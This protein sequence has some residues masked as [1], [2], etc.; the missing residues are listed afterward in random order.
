MM[1]SRFGAVREREP[2]GRFMSPSIGKTLSGDHEPEADCGVGRSLQ[3]AGPETRDP[4]PETQDPRPETRGQLVSV[5]RFGKCGDSQTRCP[6]VLMIRGTWLGGLVLGLSSARLL[7]KGS[8]QTRSENRPN[9]FYRRQPEDKPSS[10]PDVASWGQADRCSQRLC[11]RPD[12]LSRR[13]TET[14]RGELLRRLYTKNAG[15]QVGSNMYRQ[16]S[17]HRTAYHAPFGTV[18]ARFR[19]I[20]RARCRLI[21]VCRGIASLRPV[22]GFVQM[23]WLEP[24][25]RNWQP[26]AC[27]CASNC[28]RFIPR[29]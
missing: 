13:R 25:R 22:A 12:P 19:Q 21:S 3:R 4:R 15:V 17:C 28:R 9:S 8:N 20:A 26:S 23:E 10:G 18:T 1:A 14:N 27:R 16:T 2:A 24:S 6:S 11:G 7:C 29:S 5:A